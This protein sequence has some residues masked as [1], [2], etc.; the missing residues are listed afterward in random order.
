MIF[1]VES[2][3]IKWSNLCMNQN[4]INWQWKNNN[5][6]NI[7]GLN[8]IHYIEALMQFITRPNLT[9]LEFIESLWMFEQKNRMLMCVVKIVL[10]CSASNLHHAY[11]LFH[12]CRA[13]IHWYTKHWV[14][15]NMSL[16]ILSPFATSTSTVNPSPSPISATWF[17]QA[18]GELR[19]GWS[20]I[21]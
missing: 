17:L 11:Y 13:D 14:R 1:Q 9:R 3:Q 8:C 15:D 19:R 18:Q 12:K 10:Y 5:L 6:Q 4:T 2:M 16:L 7:V 21:T 20:L